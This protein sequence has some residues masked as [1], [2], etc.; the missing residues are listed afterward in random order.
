VTAVCDAY[1][2]IWASASSLHQP[3]PTGRTAD[4]RRE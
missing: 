2:A 4:V 3:A 1:E